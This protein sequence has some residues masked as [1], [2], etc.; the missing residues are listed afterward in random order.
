MLL[1]N[2]FLCEM[3][4]A[5]RRDKLRQVCGVIED[6]ASELWILMLR[7]KH[8]PVRGSRMEI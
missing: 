3:V 1:L 8:S 2:Y 7:H 5:C 4:H 6:Q